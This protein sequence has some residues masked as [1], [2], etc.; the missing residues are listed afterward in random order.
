MKIKIPFVATVAAWIR[1]AKGGT[2]YLC[3]R[4]SVHS[5]GDLEIVSE[6]LIWRKEC[7]AEEHVVK[8]ER[9]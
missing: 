7:K 6:Y 1:R 9:H 4:I 2:W 5:C 3:R 8:V